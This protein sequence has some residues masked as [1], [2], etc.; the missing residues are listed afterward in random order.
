MNFYEPRNHVVELKAEFDNFRHGNYPE[1]ITGRYTSYAPG[2]IPVFSFHDVEPK[3][4]E[5]QLAY[6]RGNGYETVT[7]D[8]YMER[9]IRTRGDR[10]V[11]LTFD[12]GRASLYKTAWPLL[13]S[14]GMKAVAFVLPGEIK[15]AAT[16]R[17]A[18]LEEGDE[19]CTWTEISAMKDIIDFQ[20]HTLFH[21]IMFTSS[22]LAGFF[23][24]AV[25]KGWARIDWPI[26]RDDTSD[27]IERDYPLGTPFYEMDSRLSEKRRVI[28]PAITREICAKYVED[29]GGEEFFKDRAWRDKLTKVHDNAL[30]GAEFVTETEEERVESVRRMMSESKELLEKR[31]P[32]SKVR[33]VCFP[34]TIGGS[35]AVKLAAEAGYECFFWGV[36][37]P[38]YAVSRGGV[39]NVTRIKDDYIFRLPGEGRWPLRKVL[40][41]KFWRRFRPFGV[42]K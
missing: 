37:A 27:R 23:T 36:T 3:K 13:K 25:R 34:F 14:Y 26:T 2:G 5:A 29:N 30:V 17:G 18:T 38:D 16:P 28:E 4:F 32:D 42:V 40:T 19:L 41:D 7:A 1:F 35:T 10:L 21:W 31:L 12:D 11:M 8:E 20:S 9:A 33:H 39:R 6:L 15:D 24:P 22:K